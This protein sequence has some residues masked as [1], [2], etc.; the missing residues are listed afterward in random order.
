MGQ[1]DSLLWVRIGGT[2]MAGDTERQTP[3]TR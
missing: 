1:I 3:K 2:E